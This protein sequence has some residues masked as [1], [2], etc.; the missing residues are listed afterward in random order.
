M[1]RKA[2]A[3]LGAAA[4]TGFALTACS[5]GSS[6]GPAKSGSVSSKKGGLI[7]IIVNDPSN[8]YWL[9]EGNV[10]EAEAKRLG[11]QATVGASDGDTNTELNLVQTAIANKSRAIIL[12][13]ANA[14][15]SIGAVKKAIAA[16][17]PVFLVNAEI[18]QQ[19]LAK[20]Q[21]VSNNAQGAA[22]GAEQWVKDVGQKG[23]YA[24][25]YGAPSDNNAATRSDGYKTVL[26]STRACTRSTSRSPT[27]IAPRATTRCRPC[28]APTRTS[29]VSSPVTT[30]WRSARS[31]RSSR[32]GR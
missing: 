6:S 11:Y 10:A 32:L 19:G 28:C 21:L 20:A 24:E 25:L 15:G 2:I 5:S 8:P 9:A 31:R 17:I 13:P 26:S 12:D 30:R 29:S 4:V 18:D 23:D 1:F 16:H 14:V 27:G 7:N 3:L 22:L